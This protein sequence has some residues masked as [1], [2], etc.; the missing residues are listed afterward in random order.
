MVNRQGELALQRFS[1]H[2]VSNNVRREAPQEE[3]PL[4]S[5]P[6]L[7]NALT[8]PD[9]FIPSTQNNTPLVALQPGTPPPPLI[10]GSVPPGTEPPPV[11]LVAHSA[12]HS[13][14]PV[15]TPY[16]RGD[17]LQQSQ[18]N[19]RMP[20]AVALQYSLRPD[21]TPEQK[22]LAKELARQIISLLQNVQDSRNQQGGGMSNLDGGTIGA[23]NEVFNALRELAD[24]Q[25]SMDLNNPD[26]L[27]EMR[28][29]LSVN[30]PDGSRSE[31][32][33]SFRNIRLQSPNGQVNFGGSDLSNTDFTNSDLTGANF[34]GAI[35][36]NTNFA[37]ANFQNA[38]MQNFNSTGSNFNGANFNGTNITMASFNQASFIGA[39]L[40]TGSIFA[41]QFTSS[42][43]Y[44]S[45]T[46]PR[47]FN[48]E[49]NGLSAIDS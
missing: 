45:T 20:M 1:M 19:N 5:L 21:L 40:N 3:S 33:I 43:Y 38:N 8:R 32:G 47:G 22:K 46:F 9:E 14:P 15:V 11:I 41:A 18:S 27:S 13:H 35:A 44:S 31:L 12:S 24:G 30:N 26:L 39:N 4:V 2:F 42:S 17:L 7:F 16:V 48:P 36:N 49:G 37:G 23:I 25:I 6:R 10:L 29:G 28:L 34:Q